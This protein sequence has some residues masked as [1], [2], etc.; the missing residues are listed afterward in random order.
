LRKYDSHA[1]FIIFCTN[2]KLKSYRK[3]HQPSLCSLS[4]DSRVKNIIHLVFA[5]FVMFE[6]RVLHTT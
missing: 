4:S 6:N 3:L 2:Y 5:L 1:H